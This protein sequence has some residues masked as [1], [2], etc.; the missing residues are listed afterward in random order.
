M[1]KLDVQMFH[2]ESW[3]PVYFGAKR[4]RSCIFRHNAILT[5]YKPR[6]VSPGVGFCTL[7]VPASSSCIKRCIRLRYWSLGAGVQG[8]SAYALRMKKRRANGRFSLIGL[9]VWISF[10]A[11]TLLVGCREKLCHQR[12][13][14]GPNGGENRVELAKSIIHV[15]LERVG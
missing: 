6:W 5:L 14:S 7:W 15:Q 9:C 4:S 3:K 10:I 12:S 8:S 13:R 11:L 1:Y 2:N